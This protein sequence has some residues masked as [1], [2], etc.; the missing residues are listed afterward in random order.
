[1][2][3]RILNNY[4]EYVQGSKVKVRERSSVCVKFKQRDSC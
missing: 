3:W 4:D 1:M 2:T